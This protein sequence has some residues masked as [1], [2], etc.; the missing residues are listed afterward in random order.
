MTLPLSVLVP[1]QAP[2][3]VLGEQVEAA[4]DVSGRYFGPDAFNKQNKTLWPSREAG[5]WQTHHVWV[6]G[7]LPVSASPDS[8][9]ICVPGT[10]LQV[11][12]DLTTPFMWAQHLALMPD[13]GVLAVVRGVC[14]IAG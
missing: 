1:E 13:L 4:R 7:C 3:E 12:L 6:G 11:P 14:I 5:R 8:P 2:R 9:G 10:T